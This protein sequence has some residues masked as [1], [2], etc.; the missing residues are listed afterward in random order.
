MK[1]DSLLKLY[2]VTAC[3]AVLMFLGSFAIGWSCFDSM[4]GLYL[5]TMPFLIIAIVA[6]LAFGFTPH[7]SQGN[8]NVTIK[9]EIVPININRKNPIE[10]QNNL[11]SLGKIS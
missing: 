7:N 10:A 6:L 3:V 9:A 8:Q 2:L 1:N 5:I 11:Y 4:A